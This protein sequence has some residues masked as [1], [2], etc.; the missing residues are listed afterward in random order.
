MKRHEAREGR[1]RIPLLFV[2]ESSR[3]V[4]RSINPL[5]RNA[6]DLEQAKSEPP[7][8]ERDEGR[9]F[10]SR[11]TRIRGSSSMTSCPMILAAL[12][13]EVSLGRPPTMAITLF[14]ITHTPKPTTRDP[15]GKI[16]TETVYHGDSAR[17]SGAYA[18][19]REGLGK[20]RNGS[21][22]SWR[23]RFF[24]M[25]ILPKPATFDRLGKNILKTVHYSDFLMKKQCSRQNQSPSTGLGK[26]EMETVYHGDC[27][28]KRHPIG[29]TIRIGEIIRIGE[30]IGRMALVVRA[31]DDNRPLLLGSLFQGVKALR[32]PGYNLGFSDKLWV[33]RLANPGFQPLDGRKSATM[34]KPR[35]LCELPSVPYCLE[36][37]W[38]LSASS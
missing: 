4:I 12:F 5:P 19:N 35:S 22:L 23:S 28:T 26:I 29:E 37:D 1:P 20:N 3:A 6:P 7:H 27:R 8:V 31:I 33:T 24:P 18:K 32:N 34:R 17:K 14:P 9:R 38:Q 11:T 13:A 25:A 10:S 30:T 21:R 2:Q 15:L 16:S 36:A